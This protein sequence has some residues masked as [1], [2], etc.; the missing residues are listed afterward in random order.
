VSDDSLTPKELDRLAARADFAQ[1]KAAGRQVRTDM[2][3][4]KEGG[5]SGAVDKSLA[6]FFARRNK[7]RMK[8]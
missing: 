3:H 5:I 2:R 6:A 7:R 4:G 8:R 1:D